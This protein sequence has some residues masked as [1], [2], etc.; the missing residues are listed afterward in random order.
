MTGQ[1]T[2]Y[3]TPTLNGTQS[4]KTAATSSGEPSTCKIP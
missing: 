3:S 4:E 1:N 2:G